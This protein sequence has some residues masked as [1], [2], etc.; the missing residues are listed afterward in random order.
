VV[1]GV[2]LFNHPLNPWKPCPW[3]TR[4]YGFI[5]PNPLHF[6]AK[7]WQ[8]AAGKSVQLRYRVVAYAGTPT[9]AG[10]EGIYKAWAA[11]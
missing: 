10:L 11:A 6:A 2:A 5:S 7:P 9:D 8:L 3:F 4:D 1:E